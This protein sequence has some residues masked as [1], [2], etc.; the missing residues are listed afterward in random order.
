MVMVVV[1]VA[2]FLHS[3]CGFVSKISKVIGSTTTSGVCETH[4]WTA[5]ARRPSTSVASH[6]SHVLRSRVSMVSWLS[7]DQKAMKRPNLGAHLEDQ[8][9]YE[10]RMPD[11]AS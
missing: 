9:G 4:A 6:Q 8:T 11:R 7:C 1:V 10:F 2:A 3:C 5:I